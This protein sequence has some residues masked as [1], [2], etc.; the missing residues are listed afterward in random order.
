MKLGMNND[1]IKS[2]LTDIILANTF[3]EGN[4]KENHNL[5]NDLDYDSISFS[6]LI[7]EI[8]DTFGISITKEDVQN[9]M[10]TPKKIF[11]LILRKE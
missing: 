3:Y 10:D 7:V 4:V 2:K 6:A 8:E 11:D 5:F 9:G 1:K